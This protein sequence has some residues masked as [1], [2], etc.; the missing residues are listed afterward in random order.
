MHTRS[1]QIAFLKEASYIV[2]VNP[3][4]VSE[5]SGVT[6]LNIDHERCCMLKCS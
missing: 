6:L 1:M 4:T 3:H 5:S 2:K